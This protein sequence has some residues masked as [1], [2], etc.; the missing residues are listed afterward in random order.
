VESNQV[1]AAQADRLRAREPRFPSLTH[2]LDAA[3][4]R[5]RAESE[6]PLDSATAWSRLVSRGA[7]VAVVAGHVLVTF[8]GDPK[9]HILGPG[10]VFAAP[11]RGRVAALGFEP[12]T[13]RVLG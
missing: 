1:I 9:D 7:G 10:E 11:A 13:I 3:L 4:G 12:S 5:P 6:V 2:L 8:E